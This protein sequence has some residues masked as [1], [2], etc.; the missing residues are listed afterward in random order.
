MCVNL[1]VNEICLDGSV[2]RRS[3]LFVTCGVRVHSVIYRIAVDRIQIQLSGND[4]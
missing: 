1:S 4:K 2:D 3:D